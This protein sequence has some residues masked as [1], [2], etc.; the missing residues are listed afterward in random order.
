MMRIIE[1]T[2]PAGHE[3]SL[4]AIGE[5]QGVRD[6]WHTHDPDGERCLVRFLV[7]RQAQQGVVDA[8]QTLL[9]G[10]P[11]WRLALL[12]VEAVAPFHHSIKSEDKR[13]RGFGI[14]TREELYHDISEGAEITRDYMLFVILSTIVAGIGLIE[15]S[16]AIVI[17]AMV[18][19]PL[20]GPNLA[21]A[22]ATVLGDRSLMLRAAGTVL[23]GLFLS[24]GISALW[25]F[26]GDVPH[27]SLEIASRSNV[28]YGAIVLAL[29]SG[30][31]AVLSLSTGVSS[32]LVGVMVSVALLPP[33]VVLG[34]DIGGQKWAD[35][36][37][38]AILLSVNLVS[39]N[40]ASQAVF[41]YRGIRPRTYKERKGV[42]GSAWLT[43]LM[44]VLMLGALIVLISFRGAP[45]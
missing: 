14:T 40:L 39:V 15:D 36:Q 17:G 34:F 16:V 35:A 8:C 11:D 21:F 4:E 45:A 32:A 5:I 28:G 43:F 13:G 33:A 31:A 24:I 44:W 38:A 2:A 7:D 23:I 19:A 37:G 18:I 20:L 27:T 41:V 26:F 1:V 29:A 12:P 9:S 25:G 3:Y 42:R 30:A 22:F 6:V 10:T